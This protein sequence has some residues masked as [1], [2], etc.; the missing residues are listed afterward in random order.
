MEKNQINL[1]KTIYERNKQGFYFGLILLV[2]FGGIFFK[3]YYLDKVVP[4]EEIAQLSP[5]I[6]NKVKQGIKGCEIRERSVT[7]N[8]ETKSE[9]YTRRDIINI[10]I[11][12]QHESGGKEETSS[13]MNA[14]YEQKKM[15][16]SQINAAK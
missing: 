11:C 5:E 4:A 7:W 16:D 10:E 13:D 9:P 15:F 2:V 3:E 8:N 1:L 6:K 12:L 14:Y